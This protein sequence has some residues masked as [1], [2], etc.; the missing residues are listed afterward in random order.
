MS[1]PYMYYEIERDCSCSHKRMIYGHILLYKMV[2][3]VAYMYNNS[4]HMFIK[5]I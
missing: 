5:Q 2:I 1:L 4:E 3:I